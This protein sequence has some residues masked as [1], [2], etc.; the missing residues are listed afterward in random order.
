M[1]SYILWDHDGVLVDTEPWYFEAT[2]LCIAELGIDLQRSEYLKDM[3]AGRPAWDRARA[4]GI[5]ARRI[6]AVRNQR[7]ELYQRYLVDKDIEVPGVVDVLSRLAKRFSMAIVTTAKRQDLELI[8]RDRRILNFMD[9]VI[10]NGDYTRSKPHP[11]PYLLALERFG[12]HPGN[13]LVVEDSERGLRAAVA[14]G[15]D[16]VVVEHPFVA[17]QDFSLATRRVASIRELPDLLDAW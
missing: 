4:Q 14:A 11:E 5:S 12:A 13:A 6:S 1:K 7:D 9:F 3:A 10:A 16:C 2:R 15:L 8:H 17:G